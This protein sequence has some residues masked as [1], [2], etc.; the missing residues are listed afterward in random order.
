MTTNSSKRRLFWLGTVGVSLLTVLFGA[1]QSSTSSA[2]AQAAPSPTPAFIQCAGGALIQPA[3]GQSCPTQQVCFNGTTAQ[4]PPYGP[5]CPLTQVCSNG[6]TAVLPPYGQ[7]CPLTQTCANG[8][9]AVLPPTGP[10]CPPTQVC[11]NGTIAVLPP[12]GSGCSL[13]TYACFGLQ[14]PANQLCSPALGSSSLGSRYVQPQVVTPFPSTS[15]SPT[16]QALPVTVS[17]PPAIAANSAVGAPVPAAAVAPPLGANGCLTPGTAAPTSVPS[18]ALGDAPVFA[19]STTATIDAAAGGTLVLGVQD[20]GV[21]V[22]AAS[23]RVP[24]AAACG[25]AGSATITLA[26]SNQ[27]QPLAVSIGGACGSGPLTFSAP[28]RLC[29]TPAQYLLDAQQSDRGMSL[30]LLDGHGS[31]VSDSSSSGA[32]ICAS[33]SAPGTYTVAVLVPATS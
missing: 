17:A 28:A 1:L 18:A 14:I 23:L 8:S 26:E 3:R 29:V 30:V 21:A 12:F 27:G 31:V 32:Q 20:S 25:G 6:S 19:C 4:L 11:S 2:L 33:I 13:Q 10:G 5:G 16:P 7:G 22:Q 15:P 24:A 9:V